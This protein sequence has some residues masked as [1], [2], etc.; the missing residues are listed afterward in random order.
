MPSGIAGLLSALRGGVPA[1]R[2][3]HRLACLAASAGTGAC[4]AY[5]LVGY[6]DAVSGATPPRRLTRYVDHCEPEFAERPRM[7]TCGCNIT[8]SR[9]CAGS[10]DSQLAPKGRL[11]LAARSR[12]LSRPLRCR[13]GSSANAAVVASRLASYAIGQLFL[14]SAVA[15][16]VTDWRRPSRFEST[17]PRPQRRLARWAL[18]PATSPVWT[19]T[20]FIRCGLCPVGESMPSHRAAICSA[21]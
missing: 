19:V 14:V 13:I 8:R 10:S 18:Q 12:L 6:D 7:W 1:P 4:P 21:G 15:K 5:A 20:R 11:L 17:R 3:S 9:C 16:V 2:R